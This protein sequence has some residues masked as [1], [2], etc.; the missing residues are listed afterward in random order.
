M[1]IAVMDGQGG[2]L[3]KVVVLAL[4][5]ALGEKIE[6][7][8]LGTNSVATQNMMK[9]GADYAISGAKKIKEYL[10]KEGIH[11]IVGPIGIIISGGIKGEITPALAEMVFTLPCKKYIIPLQMHGLYIP[12]TNDKDIK[13][14][15]VEIINKIKEDEKKRME[16]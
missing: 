15:V 1:R 8:A 16:D 14:L 10:L 11:G 2:G 13:E 12:G 5:K 6:I 3:G 7:I 9:S 4:K